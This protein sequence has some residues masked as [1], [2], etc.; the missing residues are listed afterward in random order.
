MICEC[1]GYVLLQFLYLVSLCLNWHVFCGTLPLFTVSGVHTCTV[2][3]KGY[4]GKGSSYGRCGG[5]SLRC[6]VKGSV[7]C[8]VSFLKVTYKYYYVS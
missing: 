8:V 1:F 2:L 5:H 7:S 6:S 3:Q 4:T